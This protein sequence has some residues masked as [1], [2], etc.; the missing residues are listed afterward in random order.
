MS[1]NEEE[2]ISKLEYQVSKLKTILYELKTQFEIHSTATERKIIEMETR[3]TN[4]IQEL[5]YQI[6]N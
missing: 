3:Y 6:N 2:K 4:E 1:D 5:H